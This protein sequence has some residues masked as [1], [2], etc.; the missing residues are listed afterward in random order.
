M[1]VFSRSGALSVTTGTMRFRFPFTA[2]LIGVSAALNTASSSGVVTFV[3]KKNG[4]S[5]GTYSIFA[6]NNNVS[7]TSLTTSMAV[8]DYLTVD[9]TSAGTGASDLT[10]FVRYGA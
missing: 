3:V 10:V 5:I 7:E 6:P 1:A 8:G 4:T 2:T 9:I